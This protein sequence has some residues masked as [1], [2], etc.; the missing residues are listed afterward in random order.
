MSGLYRTFKQNLVPYFSDGNGRDRYIVYNNAGF[1]RN[2]PLTPVN[3]YKTGTMFG[4]KIITKNN[5]PSAKV[6]NFHYYSDGTGRDKYILV[7]GGGLFYD[8]KPLSSYKLTDFLRKNDE[9]YS[10]PR[11]KKKIWITKSM[12]KYNKIL[13]DKEKDLI[14]R[15]YH[16]QKSKFMRKQKPEPLLSF[17]EFELEGSN[18]SRLNK[19]NNN[20]MRRMN[21]H[22]NSNSNN[23]YLI[24]KSLKI[25]EDNA[26]TPLNKFNF[27]RKK[28]NI[29]LIDSNKNFNLCRLNYIPSYKSKRYDIKHRTKLMIDAKNN[30]YS[31]EM[32]NNALSEI[33]SNTFTKNFKKLDNYKN[34][35]NVQNRFMILRKHKSVQN[36]NDVSGEKKEE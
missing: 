2:V 15:L 26:K 32:S 17:S 1:F 11:Y 31:N 18:T 3:P 6:P 8:S 4:T 25:F 19:T 28:K 35:K 20:F 5:S 29:K 22:D 14:T 23:K 9:I 30:E 33:Q 34:V 27:I 21:L 13:K 7:N 36:I 12:L 24:P 10:S 16:N